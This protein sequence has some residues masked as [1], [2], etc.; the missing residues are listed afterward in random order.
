M[1]WKMQ[2]GESTGDETHKSNEQEDYVWSSMWKEC[3]GRR[4]QPWKLERSLQQ[5]CS[6]MLEMMEPFF[7]LNRFWAMRGGDSTNKPSDAGAR[8]QRETSLSL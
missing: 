8:L 2:S 7:L 4:L 5:M 1:Q 3:G 6:G